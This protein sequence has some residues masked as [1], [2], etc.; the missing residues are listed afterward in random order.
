MVILAR[1]L[2]GLLA[3]ATIALMLAFTTTM[4]VIALESRPLDSAAMKSSPEAK[5][6]EAAEKAALTSVGLVATNRDVGIRAPIARAHA[7]EH[8]KGE[9]VLL[10]PGDGGAA[11]FAPLMGEL[12]KYH[13]YVLDR[14]GRGLTDGIDYQGVDLRRHAVVFIKNML[15]SLGIG[16]VVLVGSGLGGDFA[17]WYA[18]AHPDRVAGI[19]LLGTP[20]GALGTGAPAPMQRLTVDGLSQLLSVT[21]SSHPSADAARA[22]YAPFLGTHATKRMSAEVLETLI[23]ADAMPG[24]RRGQRTLWRDLL[25]KKLTGVTAEEL[26]QL[27]PPLLWV[28]GDG[29]A[30]A[31]PAFV[32]R[33]KVAAPAAEWS[34]LAGAGNAPWLDDAAAVAAPIAAFLDRVQPVTPA[35]ANAAVPK[36]VKHGGRPHSDGSLA[37]GALPDDEPADPTPLAIPAAQDQPK[38]AA[39]PAQDPPK[40]AKRPAGP[41]DEDE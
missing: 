4:G 9:P 8:G 18:L 40:P 10:L 35:P 28:W 22:R 25:S 3:I 15:N 37:V 12:A 27:K 29:D 38:P 23:S 7:F 2:V 5:A 41:V 1:L 34:V 19:I 26:A 13:L 16:R 33:A 32:G 6:Y 30:Y 31:D 21:V 24:S 17:I 14:P 20:A 39:P 36:P 11:T